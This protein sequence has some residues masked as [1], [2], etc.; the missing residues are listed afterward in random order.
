MVLRK[1]LGA[2][3]IQSITQ[4]SCDRIIEIDL[5]T[6]DELGFNVNKRLICEI[7][8]KHSNVLL[9]DLGTGKIIDPKAPLGEHGIRFLEFRS[10]SLAVVSP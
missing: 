6:V 4:H 3:R 2:A 8:G 7:M 1:H 10:D 5:E 9:I